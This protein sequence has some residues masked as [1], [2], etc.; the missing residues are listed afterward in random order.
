MK[1]RDKLFQ[2]WLNSKS[3]S[4]HLNYKNKRNEMSM[5]IKLA[6]RRD[7][8]N[9]IDH[10]NPREFFNYISKMKGVVFDTKING[11]LTANA[12]KDYFLNACEPRV[13]LI[14]DYCI[15][16]DNNQQTKSMYFSYVTYEEVFTRIKELKKTKSPM[17]LT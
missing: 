2:L 12:S 9:K 7:V 13:S 16:S 5:E 15:A 10:K 3:E 4:A 1:I 8:Q 14:S 17:V 6:K 11:D